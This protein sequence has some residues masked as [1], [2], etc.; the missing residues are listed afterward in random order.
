MRR[1]YFRDYRTEKLNKSFAIMKRLLFDAFY[2]LMN[3]EANSYSHTN[4]CVKMPNPE[5]EKKH[6]AKTNVTQRH[7]TAFPGKLFGFSDDQSQ[8]KLSFD[9]MLAHY[10]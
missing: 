7:C 10:C 5:T 8:I 2:A 9:I 6:N 4:Y 3:S 1:D